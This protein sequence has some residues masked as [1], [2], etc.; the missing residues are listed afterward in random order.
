MVMEDRH[1]HI[2]TQATIATDMDELVYIR[3]LN[4]D[5]NAA[6]WEATDKG[7][8]FIQGVWE[9]SHMVSLVLHF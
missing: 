5:P 6:N 1:M 8:I 7:R 9:N 2:F 4:K 3:I